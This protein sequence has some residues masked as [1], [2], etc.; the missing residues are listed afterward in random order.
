MFVALTDTLDLFSLSNYFRTSQKISPVPGSSQ[1]L[2]VEEQ[3]DD[4]NGLQ[5]GY[6]FH[7]VG[8]LLHFLTLVTFAGWVALMAWLTVQVSVEPH[9]PFS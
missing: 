8:A 7:A 3:S 6:R 2:A 4:T 1:V 5:I 9:F